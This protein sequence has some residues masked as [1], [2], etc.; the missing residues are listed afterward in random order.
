M[1]CALP[2]HSRQGPS[3]AFVRCGMGRSRR[4]APQT[5]LF[6]RRSLC[7]KGWGGRLIA[8]PTVWIGHSHRFSDAFALNVGLA[9]RSLA[10]GA[11]PCLRSLRDGTFTAL[12]AANVPFPSKELGRPHRFSDAFALNVGLATRSLA[13]GALPH[14]RSLRDGTFTALCAANVP[15]P[16][17]ELVW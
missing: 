1:L 13:A 11:L 5:S 9:T 12:C 14:L 6:L 7:G 10:A 15:F 17:K 4:F 2:A 8:A 16:S 3:P